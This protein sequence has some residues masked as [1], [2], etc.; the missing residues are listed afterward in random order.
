MKHHSTAPAVDKA[1]PAPLRCRPGDL[2]R[3][4][5]ST[6]PTL[7]GRIVVVEKWGEHDGW[8]VTLL[9]APSFGLEIGTGR[10][11]I[12]HKTVL[13]DSSLEPLR[14]DQVWAR[15][16]CSTLVSRS[17]NALRDVAPRVPLDF[18]KIAT[19]FRPSEVC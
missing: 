2:A 8:N 15:D 5:Y 19:T 18:D 14:G 7:L 12:G 1:R 10:P 6:N 3:I 4:V 11:V 13:R 16:A 17:L 9:G